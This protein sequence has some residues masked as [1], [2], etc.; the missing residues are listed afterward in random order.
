[1]L[2]SMG[3]T[4][5]VAVLRS[6]AWLVGLGFVAYL[7]YQ[8]GPAAVWDALSRVRFRLLWLVAAYLAAQIV[9][10]G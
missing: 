1:M 8:V 5:R 6:V 7:I 10:S 9:M 3:R 2:L 4:R